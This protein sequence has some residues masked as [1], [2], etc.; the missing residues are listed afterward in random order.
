M[1][2][3]GPSGTIHPITEPHTAPEQEC[4][5]CAIVLGRLKLG[6]SSSNPC[7]AVDAEQAFA[8]P[9]LGLQESAAVRP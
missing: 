3:V 2:Q 7:F 4:I 5:F 1:A 6:D 8:D 9:P